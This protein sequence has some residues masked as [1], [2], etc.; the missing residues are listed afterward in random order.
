LGDHFPEV[1]AT[2]AGRQFLRDELPSLS[3]RAGRDNEGCG[4]IDFFTR[5]PVSLLGS[6]IFLP[7]AMENSFASNAGRIGLNR[8][9]T[10]RH[11]SGDFSS[12]LS[13]M[14]DST[15]LSGAV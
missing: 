8:R 12:L 4:V 3:G 15:L 6:L 10:V 14:K 5:R 13:G 7:F 1:R 11:L 9:P 2:P